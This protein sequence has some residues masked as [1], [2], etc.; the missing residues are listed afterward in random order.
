LSRSFPQITGLF[1]QRAAPGGRVRLDVT[2]VEIAADGMPTARIGDRPAA[3]AFASAGEVG[4]I[5]P[6]GLEGGRLPVRLDQSPGSTAYLEVGRT[7]AT[8][9]HMVD[10]P[11]IGPDGA[12]YVTYSGARGQQSTVSI[13]RVRPDGVREVFVSGITNA[14]SMAFDPDGRLHV[15]SRFDGTVLRID[16]DGD[17][18]VIASD[19]GV[20]TGLAFDREGVLYVGDRSGTIF[21]LVRGG[22]P[23]AFAS[24]PPSVAAY[25]LAPA[26]DG[27]L[28]ATAPTLATRDAVYR[29][30]R[31]GSV[32]TI[33]DGFGRPQGLAVDA[34]GV[35]YVTEALAGASGIYRLRPSGPP[36][37]VIA[38]AG[39]IG[40]A[41]HPAGGAV[42]STSDT[43]FRFD[44]RAGDS[45][46]DF[47]EGFRG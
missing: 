41:L 42:V 12:I 14:T 45:S 39:L 3:V 5:V 6:A 30:D 20:A 32:T 46:A 29:I 2:G 28:Y 7:L 13:Y 23:L 16:A 37:L 9:V 24:L 19:L 35:L 17:A 43:V 8:G 18:E 22:A 11:A 25:H 33:Y 40:L 44:S 1:P 38:G 10:N 26:Q 15:S 4:L 36:E 21:R 34:D 27:G 31:H 47:T